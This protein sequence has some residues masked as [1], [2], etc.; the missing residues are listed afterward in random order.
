MYKVYN[1]EDGYEVEDYKIL[2]G[3]DEKTSFKTFKLQRSGAFWSN[4]DEIA[5][6][7]EDDG[8]GYKISS[9]KKNLQYDETSE[10]LILL[11]FI[12]WFEKDSTMPLY[13]GI[14]KK[15]SEEYFITI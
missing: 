10:L 14:I 7:I 6:V 8:N 15:I 2:V 11:N 1:L 9:I 5:L 4:R 3:I 13:D 12:N